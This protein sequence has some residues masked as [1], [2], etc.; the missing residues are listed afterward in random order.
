MENIE[1]RYPITWAI[2]RNAI[3]R[4]ARWKNVTPQAKTRKQAEIA[5]VIV[6]LSNT[7]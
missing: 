7:L 2:L 6:A 1:Q 5:V 3:D 4:I